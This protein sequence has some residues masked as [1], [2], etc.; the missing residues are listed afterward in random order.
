MFSNDQRPEVNI[1]T[2]PSTSTDNL[3]KTDGENDWFTI[4]EDYVDLNMNM[5]K[6]NH[7]ALSKLY[8]YFSHIH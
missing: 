4:D 6:L 2:L 7:C 5:F 1:E 8:E 3:N